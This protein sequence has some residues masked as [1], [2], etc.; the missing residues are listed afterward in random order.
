M[1]E[2]FFISI[3]FDRLPESFWKRSL[4]V[5][6][7]DPNRN[8]VCHASAWDMF[9]GS[10]VR[11]KMC[12]TVAMGNLFVIHHEMGHIYYFLEYLNQPLDFRDGANPGFQQLPFSYIVDIN[13]VR[14]KNLGS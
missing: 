13:G 3:G 10:D 14:R 5:K 4:I 1:A 9:N 2:S 11:I 8:L 6:P 12:T 7:R